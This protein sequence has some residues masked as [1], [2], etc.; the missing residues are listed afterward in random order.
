[1]PRRKYKWDKRIFDWPDRGCRNDN[2]SL[3]RK[4]GLIFIQESIVIAP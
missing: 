3:L 1:M 2:Y 4:N